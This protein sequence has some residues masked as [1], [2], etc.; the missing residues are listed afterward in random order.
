MRWPRPRRRTAGP[1]SVAMPKVRSGWGSAPERGH[2]IRP[3]PRTR[4]A[5]GRGNNPA[6]IELGV[7]LAEH[8]ALPEA[9]AAFTR[10]DERGDAG[11]AFNLGIL[12]E[13]RGALTEATAAYRRAQ[14]RDDGETSEMARAALL[15]LG[16]DLDT[17]PDPGT[18]AHNA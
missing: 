10:A 13:N 8:G 15:D 11:A 17:S 9:E 7:L 16:Q 2:S 18:Q 6:A 12:L 1:I 3:P 14:Q 5:S 4:R